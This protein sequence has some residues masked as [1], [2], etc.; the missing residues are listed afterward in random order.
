MSILSQKYNI[1]E[2]A[3][4]KMIKDGVISCSWD[5]AADIKKMREEGKSWDEVSF[6]TKMSIRNAQIL[7]TTKAK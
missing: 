5:V 4:V 3:V 2:E 7:Y 1:P 6:Q